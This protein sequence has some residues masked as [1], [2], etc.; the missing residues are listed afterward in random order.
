MPIYEKPTANIVLKEKK[1]KAFLYIN[2]KTSPFSILLVNI[3]LKIL[4]RTIKQEKEIKQMGK[5]EFKLSLF[6]GTIILYFRD[7]EEDFASP[8]NP[9]I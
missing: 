3:V 6:V 8:G 9:W 2:K 5:K 1:L 7:H 4:V